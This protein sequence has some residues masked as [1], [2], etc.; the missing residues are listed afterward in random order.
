MSIYIIWIYQLAALRIQPV[1]MVDGRKV[2]AFIHVLVLAIS[3]FAFIISFMREMVKDVEDIVGDRKNGFKTFAVLY[4]AQKTKAFVCVLSLI[5]M[6]LAW[7]SIYYTYVYHWTKLSVY[8]L[9]AI[10]IPLFYFIIYLNKSKKKED[11]K[12]LSTLAKI[13]MLAGILSMQVFYI[14]Y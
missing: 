1:L 9:V 3:V 10:V 11:F 5:T 6:V 12:D 7:V 2:I 14:S 8:L 13:I 4:G